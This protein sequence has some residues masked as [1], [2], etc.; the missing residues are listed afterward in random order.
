M[1]ALLGD[2]ADQFVLAAMQDLRGCW[3][4]SALEEAVSSR[5]KELNEVNRKAL[6]RGFDAA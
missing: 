5:H 4:G 6:R 2:S 3:F 1:H